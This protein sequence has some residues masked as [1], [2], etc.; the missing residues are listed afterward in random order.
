MKS[1]STALLRSICQLTLGGS[2]LELGVGKHKAPW[3][4]NVEDQCI[5]VDTREVLYTLRDLH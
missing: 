4:E 2:E 1:S 3:D 5:D